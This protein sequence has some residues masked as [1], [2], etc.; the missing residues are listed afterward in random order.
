MG[1]VSPDDVART[2]PRLSDNNARQGYFLPDLSW[3]DWIVCPIP[4][5]GKR[6]PAML[7]HRR[8][9]AKLIASATKYVGSF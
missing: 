3:G 4:W 8:A 2:L 7:K 6:A 1:R 5:H 9:G